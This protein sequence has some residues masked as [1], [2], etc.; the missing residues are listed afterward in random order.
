MANKIE[1]NWEAMTEVVAL[2]ILGIVAIVAM[3]KLGV[4]GKDVALSVGAGIIGYLAKTG[5]ETKKANK[6]PI[7]DDRIIE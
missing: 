4:A 2:L 6:E 7:K 5:V 1:I 3:L